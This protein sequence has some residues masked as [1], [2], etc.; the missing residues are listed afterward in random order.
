MQQ[1]RDI[2]STADPASKHFTLKSMNFKKLSQNGIRCFIHIITASGSTKNHINYTSRREKKK[3][4]AQLCGCNKSPKNYIWKTRMCLD[5][6][7][8]SVFTARFVLFTSL[9]MIWSRK[10]TKEPPPTVCVESFK[11]ITFRS[12]KSVLTNSIL[13][14]VL[15]MMN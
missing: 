5:R 6:L 7:R 14:R 3:G 1:V 12:I 9:L 10:I 4:S 2:E 11:I 8:V 15:W 13:M